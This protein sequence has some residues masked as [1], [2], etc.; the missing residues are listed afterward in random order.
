M[1][2]Q[3]PEELRALKTQLKAFVNEVVIPSEPELMREDVNSE[4]VAAELKAK[5]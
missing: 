4:L 5:A 2:D 3:L 1:V